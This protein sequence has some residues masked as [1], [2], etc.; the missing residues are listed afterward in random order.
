MRAVCILCMCH[1]CVRHPQRAIC[2]KCV[3]TTSWWRAAQHV[4]CCPRHAKPFTLILPVS[5]VWVQHKDERPHGLRGFVVFLPSFLPSF[6]PLFLSFFLSFFLFFLNPYT[7]SIMCLG[8]T[9]ECSTRVERGELF[10]AQGV[11]PT[12]HVGKQ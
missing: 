1:S 10:A 12:P 5:C 4:P 7:A 9:H 2:I 11:A 6:L 8:A 3:E